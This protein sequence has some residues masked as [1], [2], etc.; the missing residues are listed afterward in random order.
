MPALSLALVTLAGLLR[1]PF[2]SAHA[3][4][5]APTWS[6]PFGA[7]AIGRDLLARV[8]HGAVGTLGTALV[9]VLVCLAVGIAVGLFPL[10]ATGPLEVANAAPPILA[11]LVI[12]AVTGP[13]AHGAA[14][15]VAA[16][17]GVGRARIML[18]TSCLRW[19]GRSSGMPCFGCRGSHLPWRPSDS[20]GW[21][22]SSP[23]RS[24]A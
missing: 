13:S 19:C 22:R 14:L 7:D 15:A 9:V 23:R 5:A 21:D 10:A 3:R 6:L 1:D 11:G 18:P 16:G 24:G 12:A 4:L 2:A 8:G 17:L 20:W